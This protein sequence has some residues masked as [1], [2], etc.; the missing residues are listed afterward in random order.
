[1]MLRQGKP[2]EYVQRQLGHEKVD[3]TIRLYAHFK[4]GATRHYA[5]DLAARIE[6]L[7]TAPE[8]EPR[9]RKTAAPQSLE[10]GR[11]H[12]KAPENHPKTT[13]TVGGRHA[14]A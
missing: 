8:G 9:G 14:S 2:M 6:R 3:T 11:R 1:M 12:Q 4:A 7:E 13:R 5:N 10:A